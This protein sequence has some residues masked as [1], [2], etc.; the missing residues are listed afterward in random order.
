MIGMP[1]QDEDGTSEATPP[2]DA[3]PLSRW[4]RLAAAVAGVLACGAG[5]LAVFRSDNQAGTVALILAGAL[6][7]LMG[8]NGA[9]LVRARYQDYELFM[10]R[11]RREVVGNIDDEPVESAVVA[12]ETLRTVDPQAARDPA[13][14]HAAAALYGRQV[15]NRLKQIE[16]NA[17]YTDGPGDMGR[18]AVLQAPG[19]QIAVS[20]RGGSNKFF[21]ADLVAATHIP[22]DLADAILIVT[23][24]ALPP[25]IDRR[26]REA[27]NA[28]SRPI[29]LVRWVDSQDDE[30]LREKVELLKSRIAG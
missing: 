26:L 10:A 25:N 28:D 2:V 19:G 11:R 13:F 29:E 6:F 3:A 16:P 22:H 8:V 20:I 5:V 7:L 18:D 4:E 24:K 21:Q 1:I 12:L 27:R 17:T 14:L 9:P 30:I 23:S 15:F